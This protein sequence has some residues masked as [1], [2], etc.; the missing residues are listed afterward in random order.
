MKNRQAETLRAMKEKSACLIFTAKPG[1][2]HA[3]EGHDVEYDVDKLRDGPQCVKTA[4]CSFI[5]LC[6]YEQPA[7][8]FARLIVCCVIRREELGVFL[9]ENGPRV[10]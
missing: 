2:K 3:Q 4:P 7:D 8:A 10:G 9:G 1:P 6:F 5:L